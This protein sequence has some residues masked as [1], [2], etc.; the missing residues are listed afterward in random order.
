M[1]LLMLL[2]LTCVIPLSFQK[3]AMDGLPQTGLKPEAALSP[4]KKWKILQNIGIQQLVI[5]GGSK[6]SCKDAHF[7]EPWRFYSR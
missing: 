1:L 2:M 4:R 3:F 5:S 6:Y 7:G